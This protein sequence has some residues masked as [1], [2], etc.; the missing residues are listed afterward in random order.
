MIEIERPK[1]EIAEI[2]ENGTYGK[3][4]VEPLERGFGTTLGNSLR[5][6]LLSSLPGVAVKSIK[7]DGVLHE[8][9]TIPGVKEDV[10]EIVLN[11]KG[12]VAK[13][14]C[15]GP[16]TVEISAEGPC[17]VT[18]DSIKSDSEEIMVERTRRQGKVLE[19]TIEELDLSVRSFNCLKRAG[20][21]TV[22]DLIN[23]S[24]EDMM[25]VR[26]LGTASPGGSRVEAGFPGLQPAQG[27]RIRA[28]YFLIR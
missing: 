4:V 10:T 7:I 20:I 17:E 23:K 3:F 19:M 26:N 28:T 14:Y 6:V 1:I 18:A 2:S 9:S 16:K 22:E 8:F 27:R 12:L 13:L 5:R 25:K 15:D 21:N 11:I 24:E